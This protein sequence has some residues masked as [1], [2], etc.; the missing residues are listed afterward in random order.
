MS[1][2]PPVSRR[3]LAALCPN[4]S[5]AGRARETS[6]PVTH[7]FVRLDTALDAHLAAL[8]AIDRIEEAVATA[9]GYPRVPLLGEDAPPDYAADVT[10]IQRRLGSSPVPRHLITELR[11]RQAAFAHA[12]K[13]AGLDAAQ[14][15]GANTAHDDLALKPTISIASGET[16]AANERAFY[17]LSLRKVRIRPMYCR[18]ELFHEIR[19]S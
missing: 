3:V 18:M 14:A 10:T 11:R 4:A 6:T 7:A 19:P 9:Y 8:A 15:Q 5:W 1:A 16:T 2:V 17:Y 13:S 12:A